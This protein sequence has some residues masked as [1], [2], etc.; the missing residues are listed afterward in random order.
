VELESKL[1]IPSLGWR[2]DSDRDTTPIS[3]ILPQYIALSPVPVL[4]YQRSHMKFIDQLLSE[5]VKKTSYANSTPLKRDR[6]NLQSI[7]NKRAYLFKLKVKSL[8]SDIMILF[9]DFKEKLLAGYVFHQQPSHLSPPD[10]RTLRIERDKYLAIYQGL[11]FTMENLSTK[12]QVSVSRQKDG[13]S[14]YH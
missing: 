6:E 11:M 5:Y 3:E 4:H 1:N 2:N 12:M 9:S 14:Y 10:P 8:V 7:K 13:V